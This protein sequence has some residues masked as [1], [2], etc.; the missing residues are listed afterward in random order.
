VRAAAG[1]MDI[2]ASRRDLPGAIVHAGSESDGLAP[3]S[4]IVEGM[5]SISTHSVSGFLAYVLCS[6]LHHH[7][8]RIR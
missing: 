8:E 3:P 7:A 5:G 4:K 1:E 6:N 2:A